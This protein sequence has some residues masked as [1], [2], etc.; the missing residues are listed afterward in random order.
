MQSKHNNSIC[1]PPQSRIFTFPLR[2]VSN[3]AGR[4]YCNRWG[5]DSSSILGHVLAPQ[6]VHRAMYDGHKGA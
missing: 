6:W 3:V 1:G 5:G 4:L 2:A